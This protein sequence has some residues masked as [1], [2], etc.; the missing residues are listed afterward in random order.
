MKT[1]ALLLAFI[2]PLGYLIGQID[3]DCS[4]RIWTL[5]VRGA[6]FQ[7]S[8]K[9]LRRIFSSAWLDYQIEAAV[10]VSDFWEVWG[11]VNWIAKQHGRAKSLPYG[12]KDRTKMYLLPLSIGFKF[13]YPICP[14][15]EAYLGGGVCYS[16][17]YIHN[18]CRGNY[19]YW[20]FHHSPLKHNT[21]R[22][23]VGGV[24]K[25]GFQIDLGDYVFLDVFVDYITQRFHFSR[26][27]HSRRNIFRHDIECGGFK[28][29]AGLGVYF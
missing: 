1:L 4:D 27:E 13:I 5:E 3:S 9:A 28:Y 11:G 26:H 21:Y 20:G 24:L 15:I 19:Y 8:S 14:R 6:Y 25:M 7:P 10:R 16:F 2:L 22:N 17:L 23:T 29:G 12:L 18:H